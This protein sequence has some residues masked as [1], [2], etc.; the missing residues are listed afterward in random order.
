MELGR[1]VRPG[2]SGRFLSGTTVSQSDKL[3]R[4]V[5]YLKL[6]I[7]KLLPSFAIL[8]IDVFLED[9]ATHVVV[10]HVQEPP[11]P[12]F[13]IT[14][15]MFRKSWFVGWHQ[16]GT[17]ARRPIGAWS[18]QLA[19]AV[20]A[21]VG[22]DRLRDAADRQIAKRVGAVQTYSISGG[23][24]QVDEIK[25]WIGSNRS[26]LGALGIDTM[27]FAV[28]TNGK[29]VFAWN[30]GSW[31]RELE[32]PHHV[33]VFS[34][35]C[36]K[37][38]YPA[39]ETALSSV[40]PAVGVLDWV[41]ASIRGVEKLRDQVFEF[42]R[43]RRRLRRRSFTRYFEL[44]EYVQLQTMSVERLEDEIERELRAALLE[45]GGSKFS[46][47]DPEAVRSADVD[48]LEA[49]SK[50]IGRVVGTLRTQASYVYRIFS[51]FVSTRNMEASY[52]VQWL[53]L[54]LAI[55]AFV[56]PLINWVAQ[57]WPWLVHYL[58]GRG[59]P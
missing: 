3:P 17:D 50:S 23:P 30:I 51:Q 4:H 48:L 7:W 13:R 45:T 26:W 14:Q 44:N 52:R 22:L 37:E 1:I 39:T 54:L 19:D 43:S 40:A 46:L 16:I 31:R 56:P 32:L 12:I 11:M 58:N 21:L 6:S 34:E 9:T 33:L 15:L 38:L 18:K 57:H 41:L 8:S 25:T 59:V 42:I 27:P 53:V 29:A 49:I 36:G 55:L 24:R 28:Y 47:V 5:R 2:A 35:L 20:I 10:H